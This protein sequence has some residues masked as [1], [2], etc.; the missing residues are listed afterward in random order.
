MQIVCRRM[1]KQIVGSAETGIMFS[2]PYANY[3]SYVS[4]ALRNRMKLVFRPALYCSK[5]F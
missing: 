4:I 1:L 2:C 5:A 3:F